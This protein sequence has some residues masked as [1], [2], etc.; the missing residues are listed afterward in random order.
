MRTF[1]FNSRFQKELLTDL[2]GEFDGSTIIG[3]R[4]RLYSNSLV[5]KRL[6]DS[7]FKGFAIDNELVF[8]MYNYKKEL[9]DRLNFHQLERK[10]ISYN[11]HVVLRTDYDFL[12]STFD[13]KIEQLVE[14]GFF[15]LWIDRHLNHPSVQPPEQEPDD[16]KVVLTMDHLSVGFTIWLG[17]L[18][19]A[20]VVFIA[21]FVRVHLANYLQ[22][23]LFQ[24][25]LRKHQRLQRNH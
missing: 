20:L 4:F 15:A 12:Y 25:V 9:E 19:I 5:F 8:S 6:Q 24:M 18:S 22:R 1:S 17:M 7:S 23:I 14:G 11:V 13:W 16:D 2:P 10:I 3:D 21:E